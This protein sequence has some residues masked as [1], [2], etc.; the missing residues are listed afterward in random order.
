MTIAREKKRLERSEVP[1]KML[2]TAESSKLR[3]LT[4]EIDVV[5][6]TALTALSAIESKPARDGVRRFGL[7]NTS[8]GSIDAQIRVRVERRDVEGAPYGVTDRLADGV[9][10]STINSNSE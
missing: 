7:N 6:W 8:S 4:L 1:H 5:A 3:A 2:N 9:F 10:I